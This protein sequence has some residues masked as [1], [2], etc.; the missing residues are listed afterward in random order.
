MPYSLYQN[1]VELSSDHAESQTLFASQ[2]SQRLRR[3]LVSSYA[4][5]DED[6]FLE[7][8]L[9]RQ[10]YGTCDFIL[11]HESFRIWRNSRSSQILGLI[12]GP[13][14][15]KSVI[16]AFLFSQSRLTAKEHSPVIWL[17]CDSHTRSSRLHLLRSL[18]WKVIEQRPDIL[19]KKLHDQSHYIRLFQEAK[20][21]ETLWTIFAQIVVA[22]KELWIIIDSIHDCKDGKSL[23]IQQLRSLVDK[24]GLNTKIKIA[25]SSRYATDLSKVTA[26]LVQYS[27]Q[28]MR[29]GISN[30][31]E[32]EL[33][34]PEGISQG[35]VIVRS[36]A[37]EVI[38]EM[39]GGL[40]WARAIIHLLH[41]TRSKEDPNE[42]L[43]NLTSP[44]SVIQKLWVY[45]IH[46]CKVDGRLIRCLAELMS[47]HSLSPLPVMD[48]YNMLAEKEPE[49]MRE[50]K[51]ETVGELLRKDFSGF[52]SRVNGRYGMPNEI[53][54]YLLLELATESFEKLATPQEG[55]KTPNEQRKTTR[56]KYLQ[57]VLSIFVIM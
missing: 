20:S 38:E 7:Y 13:G 56:Q 51:V 6:S 46:D 15:G 49:M 52:L 16:S 39:G 25:I 9:A 24:E 34:S 19:L 8:N 3:Y 53:R 32:E 12:G 21:F 5:A 2:Y 22:I 50:V 28:D 44:E 47:T 23:L 31:F 45:L 36:R 48:I 42:V 11:D 43:D 18:T 33:I 40:H 37:L 54:R 41:T 1:T 27:A 10:T 55:L 4:Q 17:H 26:N 35:D 29:Q 57:G 30:Y 14:S